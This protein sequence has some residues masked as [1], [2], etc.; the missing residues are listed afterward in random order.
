MCGEHSNSVPFHR[1]LR[2]IRKCPAWAPGLRC[3]ATGKVIGR[4]ETIGLKPW[5]FDQPCQR[6][7][8]YREA[9]KC[10]GKHAAQTSTSEDRLPFLLAGRG[11]SLEKHQGQALKEATDQVAP[12]LDA[13]PTQGPQDVGKKRT[14]PDLFHLRRGK[15]KFLVENDSLGNAGAGR[16]L[17][18]SSPS[19]DQRFQV[20]HHST[21]P[22]K[23]LLP[24]WHRKC[25]RVSSETRET[26]CE[27][28]MY[29]AL[30]IYEHLCL[31]PYSGCTSRC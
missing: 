27:D 20:S 21:P 29:A 14:F 26:T 19:K 10:D 7:T 23:S 31:G 28:K 30:D 18:D 24:I 4:C 13:T 6:T 17:E 3:M 12:E 22:V 15:S 1:C 8:Q 5:Y 2:T 9:S 16:G 11:A 25:L